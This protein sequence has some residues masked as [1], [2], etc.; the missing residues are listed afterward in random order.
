MINFVPSLQLKFRTLE[1]APTQS[2]GESPPP[3]ALILE[4]LFFNIIKS[5]VK[6]K[7]SCLSSSKSIFR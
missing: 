7:I 2:P 5:S 1:Y 3:F 6:S 4:K